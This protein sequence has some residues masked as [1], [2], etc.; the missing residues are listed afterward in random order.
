MKILNKA[1]VSIILFILGGCTGE[2]HYI[3]DRSTYDSDSK[4]QVFDKL[5]NHHN[6]GGRK[7]EKN[8]DF[9]QRKHQIIETYIPFPG[10]HAKKNFLL[11]EEYLGESDEEGFDNNF[12]HSKYRELEIYIPFPRWH[13]KKRVFFTEEY[14]DEKYLEEIETG[15]THD[16]IDSGQTH[17][18]QPQVYIPTPSKHQKPQSYQTIPSKHHKPQSY[19]PAPS[20]HQKPQ[21]SALKPSKH[22]K[23]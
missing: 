11:A 1:F 9:K 16:D 12:R 13:R 5:G 2:K 3:H 10:K 4:S 14:I 18:Q 6:S 17:D 21:G 8:T 23:P 22:R 20:K 7:F 19:I 15:Y